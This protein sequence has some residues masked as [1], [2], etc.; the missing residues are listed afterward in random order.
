MTFNPHQIKGLPHSGPHPVPIK[1]LQF[2]GIEIGRGM[3]PSSMVP[4]ELIPGQKDLP[5]HITF[6]S[7]MDTLG[8]YPQIIKARE[9]RTAIVPYDIVSNVIEGNKWSPI[10]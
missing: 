7:E 3:G 9:I 4:Q 1:V 10:N 2:P 8:L 5:H 6:P